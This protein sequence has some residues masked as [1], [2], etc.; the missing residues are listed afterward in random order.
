MRARR[1]QAP[2]PNP[3]ISV[4]P[5]NARIRKA[6]NASA[7]RRPPVAPPVRLSYNR[8][9]R[10]LGVRQRNAV[11]K[12]ANDMAAETKFL[13]MSA[14]Q[15][16]LIGALVALFGVSLT[17]LALVI[18]MF[19]SLN[20]NVN[21]LRAEMIANDNALRAEMTSNY[22]A[23]RSEMIA[24]YDSLRSEM[25]ALRSEMTANDNAIR[26]EFNTRLDAL[27]ADLVEVKVEIVRINNRLDSI[28]TR[29][30]AVETRLDGVET[31]LDAVE[32]RLD[33]VENR[34]ANV[35]RLLPEYDSQR[36]RLDLAERGQA[37]LTDRVNALAA[38]ATE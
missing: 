13:G 1:A 23:L 6:A 26:A 2:L 30:D 31:R 36:A 21:S 8:I 38:A 11:R 33:A 15:I 37:P 25:I 4:I 10:I 19:F 24:N 3:P 20:G 22:N 14:S 28:E 18:S 35:E 27:S 17:T 12:G 9:Y 32:N 7:Q 29:L 16:P 34:L 5:A